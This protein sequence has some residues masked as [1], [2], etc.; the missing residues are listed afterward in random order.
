MLLTITNAT[1]PADDLGYL[2]HKHPGKCQTFELAFGGAHVFYPEVTD[3][4]CTACLLLDIDP[5]GMVR[6][7]RGPAG[8]GRT[9]DQYVN[10]RPYT[11][12]SFL[13]VAIAQVYGT[14][15]GGRC[16]DRPE[17]LEKRLELEARVAVLPCRG[18]EAF[19]RALFEPLGYEVI[20][21]Q[22]VLDDRFP[23]WGPSRY[24]TVTLRGRMR[25]SDLLSHLYILIPTLDDDK[26][27]WVGDDEVD[28]L[29]RH[30]EGWLASHPERDQIARRYL[31]HQMSL[32]RQAIAQLVGDEARTRTKPNRRMPRPK[33]RSSDRSP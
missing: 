12:S 3:A 31:K 6:N 30:G 33:R 7:R 28:K 10:D 29:L 14:A 27:Y 17:A 24:F 8:E 22:H 20:A 2:L 23:D 25:L 13:S 4:R 16:K 1:S 32:T 21:E 9:M 26:H 15:L 5:V 11:A 19:L 18:G